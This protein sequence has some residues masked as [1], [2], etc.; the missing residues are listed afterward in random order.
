MTIRD[1]FK[2]PLLLCMRRMMRRPG[3][4]LDMKL[5]DSGRWKATVTTLTIIDAIFS[6]E[7]Y[8]IRGCWKAEQEGDTRTARIWLE[9]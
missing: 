3:P 9:R 5:D 8:R 2:E 6:C 4:T 7:G 1:N